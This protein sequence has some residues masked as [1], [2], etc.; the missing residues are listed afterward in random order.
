MMPL[1]ALITGE[2][3]MTKYIYK[4]QDI[5]WILFSGYLAVAS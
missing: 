5:K 3:T 2:G 4:K 1:H